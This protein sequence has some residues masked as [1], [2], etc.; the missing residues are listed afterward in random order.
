VYL[1]VL[2]SVIKIQVSS[3]GVMMH[4]TEEPHEELRRKHNPARWELKY[5]RFKTTAALQ[6]PD[7]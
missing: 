2:R 7:A 1:R 4:S 6:K 3:M 5:R